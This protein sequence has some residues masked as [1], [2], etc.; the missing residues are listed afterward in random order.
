MLDAELFLR[1]QYVIQ[2]ETQFVSV[3]MISHGKRLY[4]NVGVHVKCLLHLTDF[5]QNRN[6]Q[7]NFNKNLNMKFYV[8]LSGGRHFFPCGLAGVTKLTVSF[9]VCFS[10]EPKIFIL[11]F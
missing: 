10:S 1:P 5:N 9:H 4:R 2:G 7:A 3:I 6:V 11:F 8:K